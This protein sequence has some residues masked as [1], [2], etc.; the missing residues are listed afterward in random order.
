M[1]NMTKKFDKGELYIIILISFLLGLVS[2][3]AFSIY[4]INS[5]YIPTNTFII[6]V[7]S[8]VFL[9]LILTYIVHKILVFL[10]H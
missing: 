5:N 3:I 2:G 9:L 10:K 4:W 7:I 8:I 1:N 6:I